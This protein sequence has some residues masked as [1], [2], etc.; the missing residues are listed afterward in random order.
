MNY[1]KD[2]GYKCSRYTV[3]EHDKQKQTEQ[4]E[5]EWKAG[6]SDQYHTIIKL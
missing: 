6:T 5:E 3:S 2:D 4:A 1:C